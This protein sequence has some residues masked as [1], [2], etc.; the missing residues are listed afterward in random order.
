[1]LVGVI[2]VCDMDGISE[3]IAYEEAL[4]MQVFR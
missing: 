3:T 1:M 4:A 2:A